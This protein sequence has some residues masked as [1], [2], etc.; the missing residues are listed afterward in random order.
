MTLIINVTLF[1]IS[2]KRMALEERLLITAFGDEYLAYTKRK[3]I[4]SICLLTLGGL[5]GYK[6]TG[7]V[8]LINQYK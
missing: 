6:E 4:N 2:R 5:F 7:Q 1:M 3:A 8:Q